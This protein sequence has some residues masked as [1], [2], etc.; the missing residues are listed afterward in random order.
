MATR[1]S[2]ERRGPARSRLPGPGQGGHLAYPRF[3]LISASPRGL[4]A[5][6]GTEPPRLA[7]TC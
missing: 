6:P 3:R 4:A 5:R 2:P 7:W 1:A